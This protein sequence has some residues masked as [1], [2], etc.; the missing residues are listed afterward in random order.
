MTVNLRQKDKAGAKKK[1]E[2]KTELPTENKTKTNPIKKAIGKAEIEFHGKKVIVDVYKI[3][4][5]KE[6]DEKLK[7]TKP[8]K[9]TSLKNKEEALNAML[10]YA[11]KNLTN[12]ET[13]IKAQVNSTQRGELTSNRAVKNSLLN[14][15]TREQ[16][17]GAAAKI[18]EL[19]SKGVFFIDRQDGDKQPG[20]YIQKF[21]TPIEID[22]KPAYADL[23]VKE[24]Y[25]SDKDK[26][27]SVYSVE[28]TGLENI[29]GSIRTFDSIDIKNE[30]LKPIID[31]YPFLMAAA[32]CFNPCK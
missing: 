28:L 6:F 30:G 10:K 24:R 8:V 25:F 14:G 11:H 12:E 21:A 5:F 29:K 9:A 20:M 32:H 19:Y 3:A 26:G 7:N 13:G 15:F 2:I 31:K 22:G 23:T 1:E 18:D 4:D 16:H 17:Y 27:H